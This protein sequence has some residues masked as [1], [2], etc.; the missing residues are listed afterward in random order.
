VLNR[1]SNDITLSLQK[2]VGPKLKKNVIRGRVGN[3]G[4]YDRDDVGD[5]IT[6]VNDGTGQGTLSL[7]GGPGGSQG[8]DGLDGNVQTGNIESLEHNFSGV[9][10]ILGRVQGRLSLECWGEQVGLEWL[11]RWGAV[12]KGNSDLRARS[13]GV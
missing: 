7:L 13:E 10:T 9:L 12:P 5:T 8:K 11:R 2:V 4:T 1:R 3:I 6:R